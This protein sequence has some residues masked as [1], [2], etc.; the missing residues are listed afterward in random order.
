MM[1]PFEEDYADVKTRGGPTM[2][3]HLYRKLVALE[4]VDFSQTESG[5]DTPSFPT[6]TEKGRS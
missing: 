5:P 2:T 6:P 1:P 4:G 3:R